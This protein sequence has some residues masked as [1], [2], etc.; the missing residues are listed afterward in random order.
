MLN[1]RGQVLCLDLPHQWLRGV[2]HKD[3][4][5]LVV[6]Q[7]LDGLQVQLNLVKSRKKY[8]FHKA[9]LNMTESNNQSFDFLIFAA[10]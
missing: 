2:E 1:A 10:I 7:H 3:K 5:L 9:A 6:Q 4:W 8:R